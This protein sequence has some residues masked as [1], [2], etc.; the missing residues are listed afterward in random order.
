MAESPD[1]QIS[2]PLFDR[3]EEGSD[4]ISS[5][6]TVATPD[7]EVSPP[8]TPL[9]KHAMLDPRITSRQL[10]ASLSLEEQVKGFSSLD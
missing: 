9:E 6:D 5:R 1:S 3:C 10:A 2:D 7:S 8:E 4:V